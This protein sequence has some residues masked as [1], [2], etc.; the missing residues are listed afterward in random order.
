MLDVGSEGA[1]INII[2][3]GFL[4]AL[5]L[6]NASGRNT[7]PGG[8]TLLLISGAYLWEVVVGR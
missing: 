4:L 8:R 3:T 1:E 6:Q 7:Q 2:L 5:Y